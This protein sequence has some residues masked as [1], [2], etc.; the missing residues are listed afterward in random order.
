MIKSSLIKGLEELNKD[1][2]YSLMLFVLY[3]LKDIKEYSTLS[4]LVYILDKESLFNFLNYYG[5][6]TIKVPTMS[7]LKTICY[8]LIVYQQVTYEN[9]NLDDVLNNL[10]LED[11]SRKD[12]KEAYCKLT[13]VLSN[14]EFQRK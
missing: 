6:L 11:V 2:I 3:K 4:E 7:E 1:D 5:G 12:L 13:E 10:T 9:N 14:Y 8:A